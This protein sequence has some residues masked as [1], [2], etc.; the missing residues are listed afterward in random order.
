MN[1]PPSISLN[2]KE[3]IMSKQKEINEI[4][5]IKSSLEYHF[6]KYNEYKYLSQKASRKNDRSKATDNMFTHTEFIERELHNPL[7]FDVISDGNPFQFEDFWKYVNSDM[8]KYL[9][10]IE[11]LLEKL[12]SEKEE[13]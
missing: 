2:I 3:I 7:V 13:E 1:Y 5:R 12:K 6:E 10:K 11:L 9:R 4:E 8:P